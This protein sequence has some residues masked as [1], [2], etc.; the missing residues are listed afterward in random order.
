MFM[1]V[2][3]NVKV[4]EVVMS[5]EHSGAPLRC[6]QSIAA[7]LHQVAKAAAPLRPRCKQKKIAVVQ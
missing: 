4:M 2:S 6:V 5:G 3:K 7:S 1:R